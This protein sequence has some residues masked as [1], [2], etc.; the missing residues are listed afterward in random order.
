[1]RG[2]TGNP[3]PN[4][5]QHF[6]FL[7]VAPYNAHAFAVFYAKSKIGR[8]GYRGPKGPRYIPLGPSNKPR[9]PSLNC[10][11]GPEGPEGL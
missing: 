7:I 1:M 6:L 2:A 9:T 5:Y 4:R 10:P 8:R 3:D 11:E